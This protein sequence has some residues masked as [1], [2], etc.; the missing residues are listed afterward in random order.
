DA[1]DAR[2]AARNW[3]T[4]RSSSK[5]STRTADQRSRIRSAV[6]SR[7]H[8]DTTF[9]SAGPP[10]PAKAAIDSRSAAPPRREGIT[11]DTSATDQSRGLARR[12]AAEKPAREGRRRHGARVEP[13]PRG[14]RAARAHEHDRPN[15]GRERRLHEP[16]PRAESAAPRPAEHTAVPETLPRERPER[17]RPRVRHAN[18]RVDPDRAAAHP[19]RAIELRFP[20]ALARQSVA[21]RVERRAR[22]SPVVA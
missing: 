1:A 7:A 10:S 2:P 4:L 13:T 19:D 21:P 17:V 6:P 9:S 20:E 8:S 3:G 14:A 12:P 18:A 22:V 15:R 11:S 16:R 5:C